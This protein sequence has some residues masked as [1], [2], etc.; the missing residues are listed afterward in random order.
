MGVGAWV[1]PALAEAAHALRG[2]LAEGQQYTWSSRG[3]AA[4]GAL[5][6]SISGAVVG[7]L[8]MRIS[9]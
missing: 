9:S 3:P 8:G 6:V 4:D 2:G 1:S 7:W 5:G